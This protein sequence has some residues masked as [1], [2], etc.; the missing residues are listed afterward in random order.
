LTKEL[1]GRHN[2]QQKVILDEIRKLLVSNDDQLKRW[3]EFFIELL[4]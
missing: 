1:A 3:R 2:K 4:N